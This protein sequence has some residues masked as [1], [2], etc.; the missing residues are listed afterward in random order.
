MGKYDEYAGAGKKDKRIGK[1]IVKVMRDMSEKPQASVCEASGTVHTAKA[2][3][4]LF[5][6]KGFDEAEMI[7]IQREQTI[8]KIKTSGTRVIV[9]AEDTTEYDFGGLKETSG[10]G[11]INQNE[12]SRGY[13]SHTALAITEEGLPI[14]ILAQKQWSRKPEE[15][16]REKHSSKRAIEDKESYKWLEVMEKSEVCIE[17]LETIHVS[18]PTDRRSV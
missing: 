9:I 13:Q 12:S 15:F 11:H 17:G 5:A 18:D 6:N 16:G 7:K 10:L 8:E 3:Y 2:A 1:R 4:R 14:G